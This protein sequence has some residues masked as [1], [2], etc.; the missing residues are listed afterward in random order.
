MLILKLRAVIAGL[1][2]CCFGASS[3]HALIV[4]DFSVGASFITPYTDSG[5]AVTQSS[6][7]TDHVLGGYRELLFPHN[8][9]TA[10]ASVAILD[11]TAGLV[12]FEN[13]GISGGSAIYLEY[14]RSATGGPEMGLDLSDGTYDRFLVDIRQLTGSL[15]GSGPLNMFVRATLFTLERDAGGNVV[16]SHFSNQTVYL[17]P[18]DSPQ[19]ISF[20]LAN[21]PGSADLAEI[22]G[23]SFSVSSFGTEGSVSIGTIQLTPEPGTLMLLTLGGVALFPLRRAP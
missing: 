9:S 20:P 16:A 8:F 17:S 2:F 5:P 19:T 4:D 11:T 14:G 1:C 3:V 23:L 18:S 13:G 15:K 22:D 6:L 10:D 12:R 7:D 21:F